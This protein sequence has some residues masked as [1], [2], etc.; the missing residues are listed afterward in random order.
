MKTMGI[1]LLII[2]FY[3]IQLGS[4]TCSVEGTYSNGRS[5]KFKLKGWYK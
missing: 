3:I 1:I 2:I 4:R 5:F